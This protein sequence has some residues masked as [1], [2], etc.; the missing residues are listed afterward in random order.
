[1][2]FQQLGDTLILSNHISKQAV[3][4]VVQTRALEMNWEIR[5]SVFLLLCKLVIECTVPMIACAKQGINDSEN[6]V[7]LS[8]LEFVQ[9][10]S[11]CTSI[12]LQVIKIRMQF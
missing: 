6:Y 12:I 5:D 3:Q 9:H 2:L 4:E 7:K 1:M 8:A 10:V 11:A